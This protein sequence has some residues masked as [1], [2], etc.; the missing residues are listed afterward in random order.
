MYGNFT[1]LLVVIAVVLLALSTVR[2]ARLIAE[3]R[4]RLDL[5]ERR[6]ARGSAR[7]MPSL[8]LLETSPLARHPTDLL[9][10][11]ALAHRLA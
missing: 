11:N 5:L 1:L 4:S 2:M 8:S 10:R 7:F 9:N 6:Q 3:L